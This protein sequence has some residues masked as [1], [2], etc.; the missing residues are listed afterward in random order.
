MLN[1][2]SVV[3]GMPHVHLLY[4][5]SWK[6]SVYH[7]LLVV[8]LFLSAIARSSH[9]QSTNTFQSN[10]DGTSARCESAKVV[11][12]SQAICPMPNHPASA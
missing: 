7:F 5:R 12:I 6:R 10:T 3:S 1:A 8:T 11:L 9:M 4:L 2:A